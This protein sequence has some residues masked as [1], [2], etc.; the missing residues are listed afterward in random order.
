MRFP[1]SVFGKQLSLEKGAKSLKM[2]GAARG[3]RTP[4]PLITNVVLR[5]L[6][7]LDGD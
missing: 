4:D 3:T 1:T 2:L 5:R 6:L 7:I